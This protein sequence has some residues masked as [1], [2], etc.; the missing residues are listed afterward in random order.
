MHLS[1]LSLIALLAFSHNALNAD[2]TDDLF[3]GIQAHNIKQVAQALTAGADTTTK[4]SSDGH[5]PQTL[6][7]EQIAQ[8]TENPLP[9]IASLI[10]ALALPVASFMHNTN[11]AASSIAGIA[12]GSALSAYRQ[13]VDVEN[14]NFVQKVTNALY[15]DSALNY[16]GIAGLLASAWA[17]K[18]WALSSVGTAAL[19]AFYYQASTLNTACEIYLMVDPENELISQL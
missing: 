16:A 1:K 6:A 19:A 7:L 9:V 10:G 2:A 15:L 5:T 8:T 12:V 11:Y 13:S 3:A 4:R 14:H 18:Q 17:S